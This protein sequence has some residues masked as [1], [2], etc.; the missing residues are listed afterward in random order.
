M[1]GDSQAEVW[2]IP[3]LDVK[4]STMK[5]NNLLRVYMKSEQ[6]NYSGQMG[7]R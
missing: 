6:H 1:Q 5:Q 7:F 3:L 2:F 4:K